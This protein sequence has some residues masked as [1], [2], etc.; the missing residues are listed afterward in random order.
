MPQAARSL[1]RRSGYALTQAQ[2]NASCRLRLTS[3]RLSL[4]LLNKH[5]YADAMI[6]NIEAFKTLTGMDISWIFPEDVEPIRSPL[7]CHR[8]RLNTTPS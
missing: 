5:P 3:S 1:G 8:V 4:L 2:T 7:P 6:A